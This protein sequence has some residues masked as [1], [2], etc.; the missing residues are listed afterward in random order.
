[1]TEQTSRQRLI[2][3]AAEVIRSEHILDRGILTEID[4]LGAAVVDA[5]LPQITDPEQ[6]EALPFGTILLSPNGYAIQV[7]NVTQG[8]HSQRGYRFHSGGWQA[9]AKSVMLQYGPLTVVWQ[10]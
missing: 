8:T 2:Q 4:Q 5:L 1:M 10:P 7:Y 9:S 3:R 6:L